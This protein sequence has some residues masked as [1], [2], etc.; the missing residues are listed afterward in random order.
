MSEITWE[1]IGATIVDRKPQTGDIYRHKYLYT[2]WILAQV[3]AGIFALISIDKDSNR[4]SDPTP[5][6]KDVFGSEGRDGFEY[7]ESLKLVF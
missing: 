7:I 4:F 1:R 6:I 5:N 2:I 3:D